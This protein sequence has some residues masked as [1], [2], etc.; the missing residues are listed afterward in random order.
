MNDRSSIADAVAAYAW[1]PSGHRGPRVRRSPVRVPANWGPSLSPD[2]TRVVF[3]SDRADSP[4]AFVQTVGGQ[5][6]HQLETGHEPVVQ[7]C[8]SPNGEWIACVLA[9]GGSV[10]H[11]VWLIRPDN[12]DLHLAAGAAHGCAFLCDFATQSGRVA[13]THSA[14]AQH[15][16]HAQLI[17]PETGACERISGADM[18][19]LLDVSADETR[20]LLRRGP[21]SA[22][23]LMLHEHGVEERRMLGGEREGSTDLGCFSAD[24]RTL[25]VRSD[26]DRTLAAL[27][28]LSLEDGSE[29]VIAER[30]D[31]ELEGFVIS[32]DRRV[33]VLLWNILGG[34]SEVTLLDLTNERQRA[35]P[36]PP[37]EVFSGLSLSYNGNWLALTAEGPSQPKNIW[38]VKVDGESVV[39]LT[40]TP[41]QLSPKKTAVPELHRFAA[42]D[43]VEISGWLY[44]V[45]NLPPGAKS[46]ALVIYLHG[47]PEAQ[48][49]PTF[50]ALYGNLV[51]RGISVF[52]A[53][54][55][56]SS[57]FGRA[58]VN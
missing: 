24:G 39:P 29:R 20:A 7:V 3:I 50:S 6:Q 19:L 12:R 21:R 9:P 1:P 2:G 30:N 8:W 28:A 42:A 32:R 16:S 26:V 38:L 13:I 51:A 11:E 40:Y 57:G 23:W 36:A 56:G 53:N 22:R 35:L 55:R 49:R 5:E 48:D 54:V 27:I 43:G 52:A 15:D 45:T 4:R 33:L 37:G 46:G 41:P 14:T 10:R 58:F 34:R 31:A 25:Y 47:G 18:L 44:R 17:D